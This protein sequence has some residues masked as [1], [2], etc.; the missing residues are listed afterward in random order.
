[1]KLVGVFREREWRP[2]A[3]LAQSPLDGRDEEGTQAVAVLCGLL[4]ARW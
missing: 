2:V 3:V 1:M 4:Y